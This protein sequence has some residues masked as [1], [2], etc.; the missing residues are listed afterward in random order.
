MA[1]QMYARCEGCKVVCPALPLNDLIVLSHLEKGGDHIKF[2]D[3][4]YN[5][6]VILVSCERDR[7]FY[8]VQA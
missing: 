7:T 8:A 4:L 3:R 5:F 6:E 2:I 1:Y